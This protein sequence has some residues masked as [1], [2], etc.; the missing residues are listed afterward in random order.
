M[1]HLESIT[2]VLQAERLRTHHTDGR[3][4]DRRNGGRGRR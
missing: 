3:W 4:S 2:R 1:Y